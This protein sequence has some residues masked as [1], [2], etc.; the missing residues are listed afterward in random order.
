MKI[1]D[2]VLAAYV[3]GGLSAVERGEVEAAARRDP[4]IAERI[5]ARRRPGARIAEAFGAVRAS[6]PGPR[7]LAA[8]VDGG[9]KPGNV[10]DLGKA[11]EQRATP[12]TR[13][14]RSWLAWAAVAGVIAL[15]V[16][17][18]S[19]LAP[20][21]GPSI[22]FGAQGL[23]AKGALAGALDRQLSATPAADGQAVRILMSFR[24]NDG[25]FCRSFQTVRPPALAG[26][27]CRE[28]DGW[29]VRTATA[30]TPAAVSVTVRGMIAG[31]PL[32]AAGEA[33]AQARGWRP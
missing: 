8:E 10:V 27:A 25:R 23:T 12:P 4:R 24:S 29:R 1:T 20:P 7:P 5:A 22:I 14:Q 28:V 13:P 21:T 11:R 17:A 16:V 3:D 15:A 26:V 33:A 9:R 18:Q 2:A 30:S 31:A 32:D 19:R 6:S